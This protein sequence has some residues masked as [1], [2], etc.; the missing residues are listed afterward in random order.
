MKKL[1]AETAKAARAARATGSKRKVV[2]AVLG[3]SPSAVSR[4]TAGPSKAGVGLDGQALEDYRL[5]RQRLLEKL[6]DDDTSPH[7]VA[8]C[9]DA[10]R[11][12]HAAAA[13]AELLALGSTGEEG[14]EDPDAIAVRLRLRAMARRE[15]A[16]RAR[17]AAEAP[18]PHAT[19]KGAA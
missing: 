18:T 5:A 9:T 11:K 10:L 16:E 15:E 13:E 7:G 2:A 14:P 17:A 12:V 19:A 4:A 3:V 8:A 6:A 1:P